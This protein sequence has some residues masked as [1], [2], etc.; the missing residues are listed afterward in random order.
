MKFAQALT[1]VFLFLAALTATAKEKAPDWLTAVSTVKNLQ[2]ALTD[3]AVV[4]LDEA[5]LDV[6]P[7]GVFTTR[8]RWVIRLANTEGRNY[9]QA[10]VSYDQSCEK[11]K[12][13]KAWVIHPDG[14]VSSYGKN[15]IIDQAL[16]LSA[17]ELYGNAHLQVIDVGE[18]VSAGSVFGF[19]S[20][21]EE[22]SISA[23]RVWHFQGKLPVERSS[24]TV[25]LPVGWTIKTHLFNLDG[26]IPQVSG[27]STTWAVNRLAA[28]KI[29]PMGPD[30]QTTLPGI[31]IDLRSPAAGKTN[32]TRVNFNTWNDVAAYFTG[33]YETS[34]AV[35]P[36]IKA[37]AEAIVGAGSTLS[38]RI[39][40]LCRFAQQVNYIS[41]NL[42]GGNLGGYIPRT[43][44]SVLRCNYG[45]CKDKSTL[46]RALLA[47]LGITSYP[48][49]VYSG[50]YDRVRESWVSPMQFNHC[51]VGIQVDDSITGPAVAMHPTLGRLMFFD[52]TDNTTPPGHLPSEDSESLALILSNQTERLYRLP[53][54]TAAQN[55]CERLITAKLSGNGRMTGRIQEVFT[56]QV[57]AR[58]RGEY[59]RHS[60][61]DYERVIQRWL[62][63]TLP[64]PRTQELKVDDAFDDARFTLTVNFETEN[65]GKLMR[66][67]LLVFKPV[68]VGRRESTAL[69]KTPRSQPVI[70]SANFF[71]DRTEIE[72]PEGFRV[73]EKISPVDLKTAFGHYRAK[74]TEASGKIVFERS[75]ELSSAQI[76]AAD[77]ES[78]RAF[79]EKILQSEQT[80]VVLEKL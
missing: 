46:L 78:V 27:S 36:T 35:D 74:A 5:V 76:P 16:H 8:L 15:R 59:R 60:P 28:P 41:I 24:Y 20:V 7:E 10:R 32:P 61:S 57:A 67:R 34:A 14:R 73:D 9:A 58:L 48:V 52:P 42:D 80:P 31:A 13:L 54:T 30:Q 71:S 69:L 11:V 53:G 22:R 38:E 37:K 40:A 43:A 68:M 29:E 4:L 39:H 75:L 49:I 6:S 26:L 70:L 45:D 2:P 56:D 1:L 79:F 63:T 64:Q 25:N 66:D 21:V 50:D 72:L 62:A 65:Y 51:I 47:S 12:T 18:D 55:R 3:P 17:L 33:K 44:P 77:Y 23:Q 19:E